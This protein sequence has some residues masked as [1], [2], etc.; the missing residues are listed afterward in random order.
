MAS[1]QAFWKSFCEALDRTSLFERWPG[2]KYADH[3]RGNKELHAILRDIFLTKTAAE[4]IDFGKAVNTPI[5]PVN[6]PK[7]LGADPQFQERLPWIPAARLGAEQIPVPLKPV[8]ADDFEPPTKAPEVGEH[9]N[10]VLR[11]VLGYDEATI[12]AKRASGAFG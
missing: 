12:E 5:A 8:G 4:W 10:A 7:D 11:D 9:T 6:T 3:A 1:E 2:A